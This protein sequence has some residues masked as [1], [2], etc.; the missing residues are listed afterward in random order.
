MQRSLDTEVIRFI[1]YLVVVLETQ[2][3]D[4][5]LRIQLTTLFSVSF[6]HCAIDNFTVVCKGNELVLEI[7]LHEIHSNKHII[8]T[9][10]AYKFDLKVEIQEF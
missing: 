3:K 1:E 7:H 10:T 9:I 2:Q 5:C 4:F 8:E 6:S